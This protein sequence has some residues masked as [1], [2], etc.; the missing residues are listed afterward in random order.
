MLFIVLLNVTKQIKMKTRTTKTI[1]ATT[2]IGI[3][4][5]TTAKAQTAYD[6]QNTSN[7]QQQYNNQQQNYQYNQPQPQTYQYAQPYAEESFYYYPN[8]NV[9]FDINLNRYIYFNGF[10]W[11]TANILPYSF[12][13]NG[14]PRFMVYHRG[15]QVWLD[16]AIHLKNYYHRSGV[17]GYRQ[18]MV[19]YS[20]NHFRGTAAFAGRGFE[21]RGDNRG[22]WHGGRR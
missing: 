8:A 3:G 9:Y 1:I 7:Q 2:I 21:R 14:M 19:A 16:N 12:Y 17:G 18:P 15:P 20:N 4:L 11:I 10:S 6:D 13:I 22:G 5:F